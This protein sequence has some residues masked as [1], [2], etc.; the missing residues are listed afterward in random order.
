MAKSSGPQG[1]EGL[2]GVREFDEEKVGPDADSIGEPVQKTKAGL[3]GILALA[4]I[5]AIGIAA[6]LVLPRMLAGRPVDPACLDDRLDG[7][8]DKQSAT[9]GEVE[10][11]G[12]VADYARRLAGF[13][14]DQGYR[15]SDFADP[16]EGYWRGEEG[17]FAFARDTFYWSV[18]LEGDDSE[19]YFAGHYAWLPG[20][21]FE[22]ALGMHRGDHPCYTV[23]LRY[24]ETMSGG[25]PS[26]DLYYGGLMIAQDGL[27]KPVDYMSVFNMRTG[28]SFHV[29]RLEQ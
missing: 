5:A 9:Q 23:F 7:F 6:A 4:L 22:E 19:Y 21:E 1:E 27:A 18:A 8:F 3:A 15:L 26:D 24:E 14:C 10:F 2:Q 28:G 29:D 12:R 16:V 11:Q 17:Y 20:C 13:S 25:A